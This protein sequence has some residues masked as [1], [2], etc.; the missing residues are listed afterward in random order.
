MLEK[1]NYCS[2]IR[3]QIS[4][5]RRREVPRVEERVLVERRVSNLV[6]EG[7]DCDWEELLGS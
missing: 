5:A 4:V 6:G 1:S 7:K 3:P 2:V